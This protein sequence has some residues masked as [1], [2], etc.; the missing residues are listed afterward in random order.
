MN[1]K[2]KTIVGVSSSSHGAR[3]NKMVKIVDKYED[4]NCEIWYGTKRP[5]K[6]R[7]TYS[8]LEPGCANHIFV[9]YH[10]KNISDFGQ[11]SNVIVRPDPKW[12]RLWELRCELEAYCG[13]HELPTPKAISATLRRQ[14]TEEEDNVVKQLQKEIDVMDTHLDKYHMRNDTLLQQSSVE[15]EYSLGDIQ[16]EGIEYYSDI[17]TDFVKYLP[18][19][20]P[21]CC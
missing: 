20:L 10:T 18:S 8:C 5:F 17:D 7:P 1:K 9:G 12:G 19:C 4:P 11:S 13:Y 2:Q 16:S 3:V 15:T 14:T 21:K 6:N